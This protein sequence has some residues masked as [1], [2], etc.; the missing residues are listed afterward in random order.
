M[1][2]PSVSVN[3]NPSMVWKVFAS[4][5]S[6]VGR[7]SAPPCAS[8]GSWRSNHVAWAG[9]VSHHCIVAWGTMDAEAPAG[10]HGRAMD[11]G[12]IPARTAIICRHPTL[13]GK[14]FI[15]NT[16]TGKMPGTP[17]SWHPEGL[18]PPSLRQP[19]MCARG[20]GQHSTHWLEDRPPWTGQP[21]T[22]Q[23]GTQRACRE[24][25]VMALPGGS[26][27]PS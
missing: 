23:H 6:M 11:G 7:S 20:P 19:A 25:R 10:V 24:S 15:G 12:I 4:L 22:L 1:A 27:Y 5:I 3:P 13:E 21:S 18:G 16:H 9:S 14:L 2:L 26:V 8:N 17:P